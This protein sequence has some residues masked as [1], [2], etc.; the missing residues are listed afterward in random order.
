[1]PRILVLDSGSAELVSM[2]GVIGTM[3][4]LMSGHFGTHE[5]SMSDAGVSDA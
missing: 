1:M 3:K 4:G 5:S 2:N